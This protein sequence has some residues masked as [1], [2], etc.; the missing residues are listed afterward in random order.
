MASKNHPG[1]YVPPPLIYAAFFFLSLLPEKFFP[2]GRRGLNSNYAQAAGWV[3]IALTILIIALALGKFA[4]T[5]NTLATVKPAR[6]LQ[7][8][9]I[10][11][12]TRN[13]M[14]LGLV[15]LYTGL[16]IFIGNWWTLI[17]LPLL[18]VV[19]QQY[20]IKKEEVYLK[21]AFGE[22]YNTYTRKV[23]RWI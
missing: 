5:K 22:G 23:R 12:F 4:L 13:P 21:T 8:T 3:L 10:Y 11:A 16:A 1:V 15:L 6:S 7:T 18:I 2:M 19:I 14:Y 9:G 20:V 17:L